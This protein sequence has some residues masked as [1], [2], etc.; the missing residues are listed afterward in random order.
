LMKT[1]HCSVDVHKLESEPNKLL[2][3]T[4]D[5]ACFLRSSLKP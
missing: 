2:L 5:I 3:R 1:G 4:S